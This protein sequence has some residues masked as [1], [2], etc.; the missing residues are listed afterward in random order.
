MKIKPRFNVSPHLQE[1]GLYPT[2]SMLNIVGVTSRFRQGIKYS[3][4]AFLTLGFAH[5]F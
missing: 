4:A 5:K 2:D 3:K 1:I